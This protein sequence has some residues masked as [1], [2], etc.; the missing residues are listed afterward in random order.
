MKNQELKDRQE[1]ARQII[2]DPAGYRI[3]LV[4]ESIVYRNGRAFCS[5]CRGY[6]FSEDDEEVVEHAKVL[7][8][9]PKTSVTEEDMLG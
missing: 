2:S 6:R 7:A 4:C 1:M 3:C 5:H 8:A 9:R